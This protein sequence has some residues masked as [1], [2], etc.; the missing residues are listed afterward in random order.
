MI[1]LM[2]TSGISLA[3]VVV[4]VPTAL[5]IYPALRHDRRAIAR[6][7]AGLVAALILVG[8]LALQA[9]HII[10]LAPGAGV[11]TIQSTAAPPIVLMVLA[12]ALSLGMLLIL[13][14]LAYLLFVFKQRD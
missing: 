4:S 1:S 10:V 11:L 9:P 14:A 12:V 6:I 2:M 13:P 7:L 5:L 3:C 8:W